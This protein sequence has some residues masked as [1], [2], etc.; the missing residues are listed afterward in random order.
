MSRL[1]TTVV[2]IPL[3]LSA[4]VHKVDA[5]CVW[6]SGLW[7]TADPMSPPPPIFHGVL[8]D[9][10]STSQHQRQ[11]SLFIRCARARMHTHTRT[12]AHAR[13]HTHTHTHSRTHTHKTAETRSS[14][15]AVAKATYGVKATSLLFC[16]SC[17][18]VATKQQTHKKKKKKKQTNP[19][20]S[21]IPSKLILSL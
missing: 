2:D 14:K 18:F 10:S 12:R 3:L 8:F 19:E 4:F 11:L 21:F 1:Y 13:A 20:A 16:S 7:T 17:K 5:L 6:N 9:P 15:F